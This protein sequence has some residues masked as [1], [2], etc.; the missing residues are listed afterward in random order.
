[1]TATISIEERVGRLEAAQDHLATKA[2]LAELKAELKADL[3]R[4]LLLVVLANAA[5]NGSFFAALRW[6]G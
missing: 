3:Y 2:D 5:I 1:M 6:L 4:G